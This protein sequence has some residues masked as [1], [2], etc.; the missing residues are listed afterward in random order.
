MERATQKNFQ[1][2]YSGFLRCRQT[3]ARDSY[4]WVSYK[5][6]CQWVVVNGGGYLLAGGG[7]WWVVVDIFWLMVGEVG[8]GG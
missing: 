1:V 6:S 7:F 2:C 4:K 3:V 8:G 5:K